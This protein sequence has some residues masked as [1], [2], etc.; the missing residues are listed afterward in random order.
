L[1]GVDPSHVFDET[2]ELLLTR[3]LAHK[4]DGTWIDAFDGEGRPVVKSIPAS[5]LY[6][7]FLAFAEVL[8]VAQAK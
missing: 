7:V 3:Y 4:P 1:K 8:R 5:T 2:N 6:H